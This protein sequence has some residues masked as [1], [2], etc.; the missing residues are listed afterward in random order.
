MVAGT[1]PLRQGQGYQQGQTADPASGSEPEA[2]HGHVP[3]QGLLS[4][5]QEGNVQL[6]CEMIEPKNG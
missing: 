3:G 1:C 6:T 2:E 4:Q 5:E